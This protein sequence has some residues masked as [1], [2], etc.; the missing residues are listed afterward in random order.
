MITDY[1]RRPVSNRVP[2]TE[3]VE[4]AAPGLKDVV[5]VFMD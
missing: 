3:M 2:T 1:L 5:D 4:Q